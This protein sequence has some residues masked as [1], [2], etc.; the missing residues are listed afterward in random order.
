MA[1]GTPHRDNP[2]LTDLA[3]S[4]WLD[5]LQAV[6]RT[7]AEL[8]AYQER[9]EAKNHELDALRRFMASVLQSVSDVLMVVDRNHRLQE[10]SRSLGRMLGRPESDLPGTPLSDLV[11]DASQAELAA[12]VD[13]AMAARA[14][15]MVEIDIATPQGPAPLE[16]SIAPR[17][18]DRGRATGAVLTGRPLG[19]LRRAYAKLSESHKALQEAQAQLVRNEKLAALG[20]LLAG[21]A[22]ELNNPI[23]FVYANAHALEKYVSRFETY[24]QK[25]QEGADREE[26][27]RL[28]Q[29]LKLD[30]EL[31]NLRAAIDGA[32]D[33]AERVR[34]IVEDLRRLSAEGS[35]EI[36]EFDLAETARVA[37]HWVERGAR[38]QVTLTHTGDAH[39][40]VRGR[41]GHIQ[42]VIMNL[43]QNA[44]DAV[45]NVDDPRITIDTRTENGRAVLC[46]R[47]NGPGVPPDKATA[48]FDPFYTTK[49]VGRGTGL[50]LSISHKIAQEH[51][52]QLRLCPSESGAC[53]RLELP[54]E[55]R[56]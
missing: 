40:P 37:A 53:F 39:V 45:E 20:R 27:I 30:R 1:Q 16:V 2:D 25:V 56:E 4:A 48:I 3:D 6:D 42:Q 32:R 44:H 12:A 11:T 5:V 31:R 55:T 50:G 38:R 43:V 13:R 34:D 17:L 33:G 54:L 8:V 9:L 29:E 52:G 23:S 47:D 21:V 35:G 36:T 7:Y 15:Q 19:E 26:L 18:D 24:F 10:A 41:P 22:H 14:S 46:V 49:D 51:G 28:R